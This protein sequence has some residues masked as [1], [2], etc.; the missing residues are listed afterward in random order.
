MRS[1]LGATLAGAAAEEAAAR[2]YARGGAEILARRWRCAEGEI[3]LI[4]RDGD[5]IVFVEVKARRSRDAAAVAI[6]AAQWQRLAAAAERYRAETGAD[7][8]PCRFDVVLVD[9]AG[10]TERIENA[11][12]FDA[13]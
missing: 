12:Q 11:G 3:D 1:G 2:L 9:R 10:R 4:V 8:A 6:S 13:W 5:T 7:A